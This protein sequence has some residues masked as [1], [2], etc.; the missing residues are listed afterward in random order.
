MS[1]MGE[2]QCYNYKQKVFYLY[3]ITNKCKITTMLNLKEIDSV[4]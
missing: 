4:L 1:I 2:A 3:G